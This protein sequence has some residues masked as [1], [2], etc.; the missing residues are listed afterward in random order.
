MDGRAVDLKEIWELQEMPEG[1]SIPAR[2][3]EAAPENN[4]ACA[5][6]GPEPD[7]KEQKMHF[8]I[9]PPPPPPHTPSVTCS[10]RSGCQNPLT[11]ISVVKS[12]E[13]KRERR[14]GWGVEGHVLI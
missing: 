4:R 11:V 2:P 13:G 6:A 7:R 8:F 10:L 5:K 12:A 9:S 3:E 1:V 14:G